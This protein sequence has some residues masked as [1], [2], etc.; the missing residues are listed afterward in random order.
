[1]HWNNPQ[2]RADYTD[3]SGMSF[4]LTPNLRPNEAGVL[5]I[6]QSYLEIP[7]GQTAHSTEGRCAGSCTPYLMDGPV[8]ITE[9]FN[10][11]HYLG[12]TIVE[13]VI[14]V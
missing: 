2:L 14:P 3:S 4:Y 7:P 1:M 5:M 12:K 11:M 6:G 9:A 13:S 8:Y 10:H